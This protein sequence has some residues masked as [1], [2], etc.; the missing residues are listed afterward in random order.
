MKQAGYIIIILILAISGFLFYKFRHSAPEIIQ[1]PLE[2]REEAWGV[3]QKYLIAAKN[4]DQKTL[5]STLYRT[6]PTCENS[7][8]T[9]DCFKRMDEAYKEGSS[10]KKLDFTNILNDSRQTILT[11]EYK[12][13][14]TDLVKAKVRSLI[15]FVRSGRDLKL[16]TFEQNSATFTMKRDTDQNTMARLDFITRDT[17][18]DTL[19]NEIETCAYVGAPTTCIKTDP[20]NRD[21]DGNGLWDPIDNLIKDLSLS[22]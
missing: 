12:I 22:K 17:D 15:Y 8:S 1:T 2:A 14:E 10:L 18:S 7:A 4:H 19:D 3:F 13:E 5:S 11:T 16:I 6:S 21:T 20:T 9:T